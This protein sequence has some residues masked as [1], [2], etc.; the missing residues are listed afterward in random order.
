MESIM[1]R[2]GK[3]SKSVRAEGKLSMALTTH[4]PKRMPNMYTPSKQ[5][6]FILDN[7]GFASFSMTR[8]WM[9]KVPSLNSNNELNIAHLFKVGGG[10]K[11]L[12]R[13]PTSSNIAQALCVHA[14][15]GGWGKRVREWLKLR[16][17]AHPR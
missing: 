6:Y 13:F 10:P 17:Q 3:C 5:S 14:G 7:L 16:V 15:L 9:H 12:V 4:Y 1:I 11:C 2:T 8:A